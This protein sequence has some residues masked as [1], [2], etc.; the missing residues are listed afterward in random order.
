LGI[1]SLTFLFTDLR[2]SPN[3]ERVGDLQAFDLVK[4]HFRT[5]HEVVR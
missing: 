2:G 1:T 4:A 3:Y 5:L